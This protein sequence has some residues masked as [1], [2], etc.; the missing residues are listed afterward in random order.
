MDSGSFSTMGTAF[1][2]VPPPNDPCDIG[3]HLYTNIQMNFHTLPEKRPCLLWLTI[4][5]TCHPAFKIPN[6]FARKTC[7]WLAGM[8][9]HF[10]QA[11][12]VSKCIVPWQLKFRRYSKLYYKRCN[13]LFN[14]VFVEIS[15]QLTRG[16]T[17]KVSLAQLGYWHQRADERH[18]NPPPR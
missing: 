3:C 2:R 9:Q 13:T 14:L 4:Q 7:S 8:W 5:R 16:F 6:V 1:P 18:G 11:S 17:I 15:L 12:T 10:Q